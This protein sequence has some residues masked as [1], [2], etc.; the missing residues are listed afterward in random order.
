MSQEETTKML[1]A[2][3]WANRRLARLGLTECACIVHSFGAARMLSAT[4][5]E[6]FVLEDGEGTAET[7]IV[8]LVAKF[9]HG[10]WLLASG[11][12]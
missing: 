11:N 3:T 12:K 4:G 7:A 10:L 6:L 1:T 5:R 9:E 8:M 2:V